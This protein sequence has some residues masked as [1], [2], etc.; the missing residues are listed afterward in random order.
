MPLPRR[1]ATL[2][3]GATGFL[4]SLVAAK[5]LAEESAHLVLPVR[6]RHTRSTVL[7]R[8]AAEITASGAPITSDF[9]DR[10]TT[11]PLPETGEIPAMAPA[12][13]A[14]GV[15]RIVHAAGCVD[16]FHTE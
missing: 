12:M 10:I 9:A 5:L 16:Y 2:V 14:L 8:L 7:T 11:L 1:N 6:D 15:N 13:R 3:T 4:G